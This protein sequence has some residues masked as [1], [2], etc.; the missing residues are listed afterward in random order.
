MAATQRKLELNAL[1][2]P[3]QKTVSSVT[4]GVK[5]LPKFNLGAV[6]GTGD[7][8]I[9]GIGSTLFSFAVA[10]LIIFLILLIIHYAITPI[11]SFTAGDGGSFPLSNT[12]DG[13][14]V[15]TKEPPLADVSA[16]ILRILPHGFTIQQDIYMDNENALSNRKRVFLYRSSAPVVVDTSQPEDLL[17]QYPES[18]LFMYLS[19]NTNDLVVTAVTKQPNNDLVFESAPTILNVPIKQVIRITVV[20]LPQVLEV[21]MNG[22]LH[23]T[24]TLRFPPLSTDTD[25]YST[26]DAFRGSVRVMNLKYWDRPL[27]AAE[28]KNSSPPL[29]DKALFSPDE[30]ATAQCK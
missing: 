11:F 12:N 14:L 24:R 7:S 26:P 28:V 22:K 21:Y 10:L 8:D 4:S 1:L 23:G 19:P 25:F 9:S 6:T 29:T 18:N 20:F 15:W 3:I 27:S 2:N 5:N 17:T 30:M 13:Q 16:N